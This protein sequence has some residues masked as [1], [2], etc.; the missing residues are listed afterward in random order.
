MLDGKRVS[1]NIPALVRIGRPVNSSVAGIA[2]IIG[3]LLATGTLVFG[4]LLLAAIVFLVTSAGNVVNDY[5]DI[6]TDRINRPE[7]PLPSGDI[8][9]RTALVLAIVLFASGIILAAFT[10]I[11]CLVIAV[12]NSALLAGYAAWLKRTPLIGNIAVSYLSGSIFL[13]GGAFAGIEGLI[14]VIPVAAITFLAML[15]R[16]LLKDAEDVE[17]DSAT[18]ASTLPVRI[19]VKKTAYIGFFCLAGAV[20]ASMVPFLWW[21][22]WYIAG[23][24]PIDLVLLAAGLRPLRCD[25]PD[26]IRTTGATSLLKYAMFASLVVFMAAALL[27]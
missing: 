15:S 19:G 6:E 10:N 9:E 12:V 3:Y 14:R 7:R 22:M 20:A 8:G 25:T 13:F 11:L 1:M 4:T 27:L 18:G 24:L 16:E 26:C 17:G 2:A 23:I 21:G 5:F